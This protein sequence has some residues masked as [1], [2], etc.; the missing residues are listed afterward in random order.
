MDGSRTMD[1]L[2]DRLVILNKLNLE[3]DELRER[4]N[5]SMVNDEHYKCQRYNI[6]LNLKLEEKIQVMEELLKG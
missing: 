2:M 3:I 6:M 1:K 5:S 4:L